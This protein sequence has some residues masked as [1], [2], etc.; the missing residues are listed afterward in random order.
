MHIASD[1][2]SQ[3]HRKHAA[4]SREHLSLQLNYALNIK[5]PLKSVGFMHTR[6]IKHSM[7]ASHYCISRSLA[8]SII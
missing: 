4:L 3:L 8:S 7:G 1:P 2:S 6:E 5:S